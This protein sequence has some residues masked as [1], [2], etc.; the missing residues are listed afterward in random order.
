MYKKDGEMMYMY[1]TNKRTL[2]LALAPPPRILY[3]CSDFSQ[4]TALAGNVA[5][6]FN[7]K[8]TRITQPQHSKHYFGGMLQTTIIIMRISKTLISAVPGYCTCE[9]Y[10]YNYDYCISAQ[11]SRGHNKNDNKY[12][13][14][15]LF[16]AIYSECLAFNHVRVHS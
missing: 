13:M 12:V 2:Y 14:N 5:T 9:N 3:H 10:A 8:C 6:I 11:L 16:I 15:Y 4:F 7:P 1:L